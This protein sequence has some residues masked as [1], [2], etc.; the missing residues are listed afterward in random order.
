VAKT[1]PAL[2]PLEFHPLTPDRW[3]D[4][5]RLF[6]PH[7]AYGGCWCMFWRE[8]RSQFARNVGETNR[9]LIKRLVTR[10]TVPGI[11]AYAGGEPAGWCS[12]A[13][14]EDYPALERSRVLKRLDDAPVWSIV[15]FYIARAYRGQGL[16]IA[17]IR[18]TVEYVREHGGKV[19][20]GYPTVVRAGRLPPVSSYLGVPSAF[21]QA[22]F[23]EVARPSESRRI[24]RYRIRP[25]RKAKD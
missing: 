14:R 19:V 13:P 15:C 22:G 1:K 25:Y 4:F 3:A 9:R 16:A 8:T 6:G 2:E 17:L 12:V 23:E 11:L 21:L 5:E 24:Y 7:G 10:G 18:A 20:E